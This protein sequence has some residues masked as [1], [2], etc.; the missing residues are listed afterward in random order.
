M[1]TVTL[2]LWYNHVISDGEETFVERIAKDFFM[3]DALTVARDLPGKILVSV[4]P[5]GICSGR[6][7][8]TEAYMG[9]GDRAAYSCRGK[10]PRTEVLF[11]DGGYAYVY[12]IYGMYCC[13]NISANV[14]GKPECV[15]IRALRPLSGTELMMKRR[16]T[17]MLTN[18][19]SGPGKLCAALGIDR[20]YNGE[21]ICGD[22]LFLCDDGCSPV[23]RTAKRVNIDYAGE[24][25]EY[26]WRFLIDGSKF[27]SVKG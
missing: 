17:D 27:V 14:S 21:D 10:T 13:L 24:A 1:F 23:I 12:L 22:R 11:G 25:A 19:C 2:F 20:G 6:I 3:R 26:E 16:K 18:L 4:T 9:L 8:E 15:L 7:V 5:D